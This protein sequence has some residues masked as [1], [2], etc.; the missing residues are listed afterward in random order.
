MEA[1]QKRVRE[2]D[3]LFR[4]EPLQL[5]RMLR[6]TLL[7]LLAAADAAPAAARNSEAALQADAAQDKDH[8]HDG[9]RLYTNQDEYRLDPWELAFDENVE[10]M[11]EVMYKVARVKK[12][13][14][15]VKKELVDVKKELAEALDRIKALESGTKKIYTSANGEKCGLEWDASKNSWGERNAKWDCSGSADPVSIIE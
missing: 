10:V 13:L 2:T 4:V 12:E 9:L 6:T 15:D 11:Q 7:V 1:C 8:R 3:F 5:P 14:A